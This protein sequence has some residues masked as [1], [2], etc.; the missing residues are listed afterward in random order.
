VVADGEVLADGSRRV[1]QVAV[2]NGTRVGGGTELTPDAVP[3][4]GLADVLVSFAMEPLERLR[5]GIHL[6]RGRHHQR[7]DVRTVRAREVEVSGQEFCCDT[8]GELAG[9]MSSRTWTVL[10]E[11]FTMMLP[12]SAQEEES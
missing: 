7:D 3:T 9:P 10:P 12:T 8:D 2:G 1:L 6:R 11:A 5:Y 4:D